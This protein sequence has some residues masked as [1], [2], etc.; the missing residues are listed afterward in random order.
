MFD[1]LILLFTESEKVNDLG[2]FYDSHADSD[3]VDCEP[4]ENEYDTDDEF[5]E[6]NTGDSNRPII[7]PDSGTII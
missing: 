3:Y 2:D 6:S 4:I 5:F 1:K 7:I